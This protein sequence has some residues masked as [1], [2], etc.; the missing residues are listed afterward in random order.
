[1]DKADHLGTLSGRALALLPDLCWDC[2]GRNEVVPAHSALPRERELCCLGV[3]KDWLQ[4]AVAEAQ[5]L[6]A[7]AYPWAVSWK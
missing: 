2:H 5:C 3:R 1:M 7:L 4:K 6:S